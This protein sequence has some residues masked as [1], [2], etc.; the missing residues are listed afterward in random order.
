MQKVI[1]NSISEIVGKINSLSNQQHLPISQWKELVEISANREDQVIFLAFIDNNYCFCGALFSQQT[2]RI[3]GIN[4]SC[5]F[6]YGYDFFDFNPLY[7]EDNQRENYVSFLKEFANSQKLNFLTIENIYQNNCLESFFK[8]EDEIALL[9]SSKDGF[10]YIYAKK[11]VKRHRNTIIKKFDYQ[12]KHFQGQ[13][14][15]KNLINQLASLHK[16]RWAFDNVKSSFFEEN[17]I[18]FYN[19]NTSNKLLTIIYVDNDILAM[20][21]GMIVDKKLI[22]H[23]PVINVKYFQYSPMSMLLFESA[24]FCEENHLNEFNFGL[25]DESYKNRFTNCSKSA[26]TYHY[27]LGM[28]NKLRFSVLFKLSQNKSKFDFL[29]TF[30]KKAYRSSV[31]FKN[32]LCFYNCLALQDTKVDLLSSI[33][34]SVC[35]SFPDLVDAF[36]ESGKSIERHHYN[37]I[38]NKE[39]LYFFCENKKIIC[40]GWSTQKP[41]FVSEKNKTLEIKEGVIL[42]D[43]FTYEKFRNKGFYQKLLKKILNH[44]EPNS[45]AYIYALKSNIASN[46]AIAKA[47][48]QAIN[49]SKIF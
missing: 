32:K 9:D 22:L 13:D 11:G 14:I 21:Y 41:L 24:V 2:R 10:S 42:Y 35:S 38:M 3:A 43:F 19:S 5:L 34:F 27:P 4:Y 6:L 44:L 29:L 25:G 15:T 12:V 30:L 8:L 40:Y 20:H 37:R 1:L 48:F 49:S 28:L 39:K 36:R 23:T 26:Y 7:V 31:S 46:K 45:M 47:G 17:R 18:A 16:E 33:K